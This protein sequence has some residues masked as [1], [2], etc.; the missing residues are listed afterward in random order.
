MPKFINTVVLSLLLTLTLCRAQMPESELRKAIKDHF[1]GMDSDGNGDLSKDELYQG[2]MKS[3]EEGMWSE[4]SKGDYLDKDQF[5]EFMNGIH[6]V[7][8][9]HGKVFE[10]LDTDGDG[11]ITK[12]EARTYS[13]NVLQ[14]EIMDDIDENKDGIHSYDE[15][16]KF[17]EKL[18][19][20][21]E[22]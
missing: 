22:L 18:S 3:W 21:D 15:F 4:H 9:D 7:Q 13:E 12:D 5:D 2:M 1:D 10:D 17:F 6:V 11:L 8:N 16:F 14:I 20:S 19:S